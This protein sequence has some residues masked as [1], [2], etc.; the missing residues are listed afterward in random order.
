L[1]AFADEDPVRHDGR[2][3]KRGG[4]MTLTGTVTAG[5]EHNCLLLGGYLLIGA[6]PAVVRAGAQVTVTGRVVP[7]LVTTCQQG[8]PFV[9]TSATTAP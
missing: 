8:T 1:E 2:V 4:S 3:V 6:D 9:V 7:D 5:V